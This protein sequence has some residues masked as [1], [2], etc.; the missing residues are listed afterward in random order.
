[1]SPTDRDL[2]EAMKQGDENALAALYDLHAPRVLGF[3]MRMLRDCALAEDVLQV[4][5]WY[6][7]TRAEQFDASRG[8]PLTWL[9]LVARSRALDMLRALKR[10]RPVISTDEERATE[11]PGM[12]APE[13]ADEAARVRKALERLPSEQREPIQ[14]AFFYGMTH[15]EISRH[16]DVPLGTIK[17]RIRLG[18]HKLADL[19]R[20][21]GVVHG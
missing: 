13:A 5:F 6:A 2:L 18:M 9:L 20:S 14:L 19:L 1:M 21:E 16:T 10:Q 17:T 3:L 12:D 15:V 7:W 11:D 4:V 8:A